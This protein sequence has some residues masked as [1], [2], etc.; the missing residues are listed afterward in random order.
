ME[1]NRLQD[2]YGHLLSRNLPN[3]MD[4]M[5][6]YLSTY[7]H[8]TDRDR[9]YA[10]RSDFQLMADYWKRGYKDPQVTALYEN[11]LRRMYALYVQVSLE[12]EVRSSTNVVLVH[13]RI[14]NRIKGQS[15][16]ELQVQLE[17]FVS[18][19]AILELEP[20]HT[21]KDKEKII[22]QDHHCLMRDWF[23]YLWLSPLWSAEQTE[24]MERL[25]LAPTIDSR[26]QQLLIS[27][28]T[29]SVVNHFDVSKLKVLI[30]VYKQTGD[31]GVRQRALVGWVL[32]LGGK[33]LPVLYPEVLSEIE[34]MLED[35]AV[36]QE[37]VEL[38]QQIYLCQNAE[39]DH[40]TIQEEI[41]PELL[42]NSHFRVTRNGIEE[43][44]EDSMEDIL[45]P[46]AEEQ[47][48]EKLEENYRRMIDMQ[49]QGSDIYFGGFSQM[50]RFPFFRDAIN[51]FVP[52]YMEH[53]GIAEVTDKFASNRF[54]K[55]MMNAGPFCNSDKYS[56]L[57]AFSQVVER[58][59]KDV[60]KMFENGEA[61][62]EDAMGKDTQTPA[63]IRRSYLQDLYRFYRLFNYRSQFCDPFMMQYSLFF[64]NVIFSHTRLAPYFGEVVSSLMKLK[65][66]D[67]A[68]AVLN[69]TDESQ[70]DLK[71]YLITGYI[72]Q[73]YRGLFDSVKASVFF[74]KALALDPKNERA[75]Y[76][77]AKQHFM[78][79]DYQT[80][81]DYYEQLLAL[82]PDKRSYLLNHAVCLTK[83][84]RYQD[85]LK[86][87][88]QLNYENPDDRKVNK[89]LAWTLTCDGKYEQA[90]KIYQQLLDDPMQTE[91]LLNYGYCLW[92]SGNMSDAADCF[93]R[94][95][96]ETGEKKNTIIETERALIEEKGITEAEQQMML[97]ML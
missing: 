47:R 74:Q 42:N 44:E 70:R 82:Q 90:I 15:V 76:G 49:K 13:D 31:E 19:V 88:Y 59:P 85:A 86:E 33:I 78:E 12:Q 16:K 91:D 65:R 92:F 22:Y 83:L 57:L 14:L 87:L 58:M 2:V 68:K 77:I 54:L 20:A 95:L 32:A 80:A 51:W 24:D 17:G 46:G 27:G 53:P 29:L 23:D 11:L 60:L 79:N 63:Y 67:E 62:I 28:M 3:A 21:R 52:F 89:V 56:F 94:Y 26:D 64:S 38:Q 5:E 36:C 18:D 6:N 37:L 25:L 39:K 55:V 34:A 97:Y 75:L 10:I 66:I 71:F 84:L 69:N 50:K 1:N 45:H 93:S 73:N 81:L 30:N 96:K 72:A 35:E 40:Q 7:L 9:L 48:M 8:E 43:M 41:M 61:V 4:A